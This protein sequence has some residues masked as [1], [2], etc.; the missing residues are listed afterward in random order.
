M[1]RL[2][3]G[4]S[5]SMASGWFKRFPL[6]RQNTQISHFNA[7]VRRKSLAGQHLRHQGAAGCEGADE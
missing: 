5:E 6:L 1:T 2:S 3:A 7:F 4:R